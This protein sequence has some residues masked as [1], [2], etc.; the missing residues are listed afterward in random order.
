MNFFKNRLYTRWFLLASSFVILTLILWNTYLLFQ[1]FKTE[2]RAKME[3]WAEAYETINNADPE[4]T[5]IELPSSIVIKNT[6]IP[7]VL[8]NARDSVINIANVDESVYASHESKL[9][10]LNKL[11]SENNPIEI[12]HPTENQFVY[13]GNSNLITK[14]KYYPL[15][16]IAILVLFGA[17]VWSYFKTTKISAENRLWAGMAKETAH[18]IGTPLSSLLGWVE[19]M[20]LD[21]VDEMTVTEIEKDVHRLQTIADRFSKIGSET[22]LELL[23]IVEE[24]RHSFEYLQSRS[25]KQIDFTFESNADIVQVWLNPVLH[26]WT[27]ENLV[28]NAIDAIKGKG[29]V[30]VTI[31]Y[32]D[33]YLQIFVKDTGKGIEKSKFTKVFEPGYSTKKRGWGL[34]LS[35]TQ[36]IVEMYHK[37]KIKVAQSEIGKGTTFVITYKKSL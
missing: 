27:I 26:S 24:T 36:R 7:I 37:G 15:A 1:T 28:K 14:L 16:L 8:A 17:L 5:D 20:R 13:Y 3:I 2:E 33:P 11:K 25:S 6:T 12:S 31:K 35:L 34:G 23:N 30:T 19:I 10:L 4:T 21:E 29:K 22:D 18:Q 9:R 32:A